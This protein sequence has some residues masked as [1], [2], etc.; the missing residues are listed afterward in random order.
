MGHH[1]G[2]SKT[3]SSC[4]VHQ[5]FEIS[6]ACPWC[7]PQANA[8]TRKWE[9]TYTIQIALF[10]LQTWLWTV[11]MVSQVLGELMI[12]YIR[13]RKPDS[14]P[15]I[16]FFLQQTL[17]WVVQM[18]PSVWSEHVTG[19]PQMWERRCGSCNQFSQT[20]KSPVRTVSEVFSVIRDVVP[21]YGRGNQH[22]S[23]NHYPYNRKET[24]FEM[25]SPTIRYE[26]MS[27]Q[28]YISSSRQFS[29]SKENQSRSRSWATAC[30]L[31]SIVCC[32]IAH[33]LL[34]VLPIEK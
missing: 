27:G 8:I 2:V 15:P 25:T 30:L 17:L 26:N 14:D 13:R 28:C 1:V 12:G 9:C 16:E 22:G 10:L 31:N 7:M 20:A 19:M 4:C 24:I 33:Q 5:F 6:V 18:M 32:N 21:C 11:Q 23:C 3:I 34:L 29:T